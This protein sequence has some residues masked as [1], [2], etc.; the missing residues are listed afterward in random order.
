MSMRRSGSV[1]AAVAILFF[2]LATGNLLRAQGDT[3]G[4][5]SVAGSVQDPT[6][7]PIPEAAVA[8]RNE[9][10]GAVRGATTAADGHFSVGNL[11][12]GVYSVEVAAKGFSADTR[13]GL[14]L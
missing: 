12:A 2:G 8:V 9:A 6:G 3:T 7:T 13:T 11:P 5:A 14:K 4:T 1:S 10:S